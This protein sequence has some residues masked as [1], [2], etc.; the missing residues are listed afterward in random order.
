MSHEGLWKTFDLR[1]WSEFWDRAPWKSAEALPHF[2]NG[3]E[4]VITG[5][6][7]GFMSDGANFRASMA[8]SQSTSGRSAVSDSCHPFLTLAG[9]ELGDA[10]GVPPRQVQYPTYC[11]TPDR[12]ILALKARDQGTAMLQR[13]AT[14]VLLSKWKRPS[15]KTRTQ[16]WPLAP[17][18]DRSVV[19][20]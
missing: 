20:A 12:A 4:L 18:R 14:A 15:G 17:C 3:F 13:Q 8:W 16:M 9:A 7:C 11:T 10:A 5:A 1:R 6:H 19:P 2:H